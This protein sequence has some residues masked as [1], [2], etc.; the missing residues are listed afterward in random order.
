MEYFTHA[1]SMFS[2]ENIDRNLTDWL[3]NN[4]VNVLLQLISK[5][6]IA[7]QAKIASSQDAVSKSKLRHFE[8]VCLF[9]AS[10][11]PTCLL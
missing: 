11:L 2:F 7:L 5:F 9:M 6:I 4:E 1:F 3:V 10:F 8:I